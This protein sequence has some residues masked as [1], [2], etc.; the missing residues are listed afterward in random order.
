MKY[1]TKGKAFVCFNECRISRKYIKRSD[2]SNTTINKLELEFDKLPIEK[3][4]IALDV[5]KDY[6]DK[7]VLLYAQNW[8]I[9]F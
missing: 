9:N 4:D 3:Y 2:L 8:R 5:A 7:C 6:L 1:N